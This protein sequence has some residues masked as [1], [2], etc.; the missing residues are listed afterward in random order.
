MMLYDSHCHLES[1]T[2]NP[3][4][5]KLAIVPGCNLLEVPQLVRLRLNHSQYKIGFGIHP[6]FI[7]EGMGIDKQLGHLN[8][9]IAEF[10]PDFIGEIGLDYLKPNHQLQQQL[11]KRQLL[12]A[13]QLNLPVVIHSVKA[14]N[15][16]LFILKECLR[17]TQKVENSYTAIGRGIVH[18]FN[19]NSIIAKQFTDLGILL[20]IGSMVTKK[21]KLLFNLEQLPLK[22]MVFESDAPFMPGFEKV[23]STSSDS[24]LYA[25]IVAKQLNV[26]LIDLI[27]CSN[28]N[29]LNLFRK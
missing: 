19:S 12:L 10:K 1:I 18:G 20:G 22:Y 3:P 21:S 8:E 26:N 9:A 6:W 27:C 24:F 29:V 23:Q 7:N 4:Y 5:T 11:F 16:V 28:S 13:L 15:D 25:Q 14:Y 2:A 17:A